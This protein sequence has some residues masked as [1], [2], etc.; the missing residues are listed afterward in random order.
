M[1]APSVAPRSSIITSGTDPDGFASLRSLFFGKDHS[2]KKVS[3]RHM[4]KWAESAAIPKAVVVD[5][6]GTVVS[7]RGEGKAGSR[8]LLRE[9]HS[10]SERTYRT[11]K[12]DSGVVKKITTK[13][14]IFGPSEAVP[15]PATAGASSKYLGQTNARAYTTI[16][17]KS[18][19]MDMDSSAVDTK[20]MEPA[21]VT[22]STTLVPQVDYTGS[23]DR[24]AIPPNFV[25]LEGTEGMTKQQVVELWEKK[26][27]TGM[28]YRSLFQPTVTTKD[29][30]TKKVTRTSGPY[31]VSCIDYDERVKR[32]IR[33]IPRP[34]SAPVNIRVDQRVSRDRLAVPSNF[35]RLPHS[36]AK[37]NK[38]QLERKYP[39]AIVFKQMRTLVGETFA[40]STQ[41]VCDSD[42]VRQNKDDPEVFGWVVQKT[43]PAKLKYNPDGILRLKRSS[44]FKPKRSEPGEGE[45][46]VIEREEYV[47]EKM[48]FLG[49]PKPR[50]RDKSVKVFGRDDDDRLIS[51]E[52]NLKDVNKELKDVR[53]EI[54]K[55]LAQRGGKF[56]SRFMREHTYKTRRKKS[57]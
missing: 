5:G 53:E 35:V 23:V 12:T 26:G 40:S 45:L 50:W 19:T 33:P 27:Y 31:Y 36:T 44:L 47:K 7:K 10:T 48:A 1:F 34:K 3:A 37:M 8:P 49:T 21:Q 42:Y 55:R 28:E 52:I 18:L 30:K 11:S 54:K 32:K 16:P 6:L 43:Q 24:I 9:I 46:N 4:K 13:T 38:E 15:R 56:E 39:D 51:A 2:V 17:L 25:K 41:D 20:F 57:K 22:V 29:S 14:A